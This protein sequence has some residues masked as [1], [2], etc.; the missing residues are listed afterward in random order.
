L[1]GPPLLRLPRLLQGKT[2][3]IRYIDL[4]CGI[5]G[6]R[7]AAEQVFAARGLAGECVFSS[8]INP[9][10]QRAYEANFGERPFGDITLVAAD[11]VPDHDILFAGFPC[12][13]FSIIGDMKGFGD[14]RG[15]LFFDI[16][17]ILEAKKPR[18]FI[19]ENVKMLTGHRQGRTIRRIVETLR[20]LGYSAEYRV[21]NAL[22]FGLPQKRERV[23]IVGFNRPTEFRW[24]E[25]NGK[26]TPLSDL[27]ETDVDSKHIASDHIRAARLAKTE[28]VTG[29]GPTIWHENKSGH[30]SVYPYSCALRA[31]ASYN[32]LLVNGERRLTPREMLR[33]Q[34]FPDAYKIVC[35]DWQT[36]KQA[37]NAVPPPIIAAVL[38][39][40]MDAMGQ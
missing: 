15:T 26:M 18:A 4:F 13:P 11:D 30:V 17:R 14:T 38:E 7:V 33:L 25:G 20:D 27:L 10:A 1:G 19:L 29:C 28:D 40:I 24:P 5:G 6:F 21:L 16:A 37:G 31:G 9:E 2:V 39:R 34:G 23:L 12:Q 36:R 32:Y 35:S 22:D 8:D 3:T